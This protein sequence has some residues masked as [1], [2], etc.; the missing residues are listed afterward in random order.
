[1]T[2]IQELIME[3]AQRL[4]AMETKMSLLLWGVS[5][6]SLLVIGSIGSRL[7]VYFKNGKSDKK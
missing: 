6:L 4:T 2:K 3:L 1:M 7:R 5:A